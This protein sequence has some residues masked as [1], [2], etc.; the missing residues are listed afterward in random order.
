MQACRRTTCRASINSHW[1]RELSGTGLRARSTVARSRRTCVAEMHIA[2]RFPW[3]LLALLILTTAPASAAT[4]LRVYAQ[5][6][7]PE[8]STG[9]NPKPLHAFTRLARRF[10]A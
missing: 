4:T 8:V 6:Y 2:T 1:L 3:L 9:D 7:T 5:A 10:E